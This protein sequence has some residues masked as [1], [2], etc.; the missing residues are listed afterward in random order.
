MEAERYA[1]IY[2]IFLGSSHVQYA[3]SL[4]VSSLSVFLPDNANIRPKVRLILNP[5][6]PG[7]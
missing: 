1:Q 7:M 3:L 2:Q 4:S 5:V 6:R